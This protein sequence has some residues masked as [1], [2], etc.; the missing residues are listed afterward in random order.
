MALHDLDCP[1]RPG[2]LEQRAGRIVR[3]GNQNKDVFIYRYVTEGTFDAYLWQTVENKQKFISQ[4]MTSKA[5]VRSCEDVDEAA[6]SYAEVKALATGNP[7]VKEK[8]ALDVDVAKLK[9]LKANHMNNQYRLED[10]IARNFPQQIAKLTEI[11]ESYKADIAHYSEHKITDPEQFSMEISG[12]VFTEKKEAGAALL[13]VCK[14][15][16]SVDAAMDIG[17]YQGFNMRIQFDSWSKEFI[18]SVK[19][20]SVAKV[21][22]G[23]DALGNITRINNLLESYPEKLAEA[24]QRLETVQEQLANAKEEVGKPFPK[25]EKLNQKLERLSELNALLNMDEREDTETEQSESKEKEERPARGSI[26][27]KLQIYKE[28]SQRESETG[29]ENRKRDFGL[30]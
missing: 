29:K 13:A 4:I 28:K 7:A 26:H 22:L 10:D 30:E 19:H 8:M 21:R 6:L 27:E 11:I 1:W 16:K 15:I 20:E 23:A 5:P 9:L 18:L 12:K 25:E 24:E 2:D 3:Q 14:D 17:S